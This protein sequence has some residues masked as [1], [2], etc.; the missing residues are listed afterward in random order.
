[1][2]IVD[3]IKFKCIECGD[4]CRWE[5]QVFLTKE[6][7]KRLAKHHEV[8][9]SEYIK[10]Y[11]ESYGDQVILKNK[12]KDS[13]DCV[14]LKENKCS[15]YEVKP[16]QCSEYPTKYEPRCPG[17]DHNRRPTMD[18]YAEKVAKA[19]DK[20]S[21]MQEYEKKVTEGLFNELKG[22]IKAASVVSKALESGIDEYFN[23]YSIKVASLDDLFS[24][25][26]VDANTLVHKSTKDLWGIDK[27]SSGKVVITRLFS[28][29]GEPIKG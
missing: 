6:D 29:E 22:N 7:I 11:T 23:I 27:D 1:M 28:N 4:C 12:R 25:N 21:S 9:V 2:K 24:F 26:R 17:F 18:K 8:E 20:L 19:N 3:G 5:G 16:K 10:E 13:K 15:V 14:Y